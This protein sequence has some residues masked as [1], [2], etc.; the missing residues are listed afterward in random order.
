MIVAIRPDASPSARSAWS[1]AFV[2][3]LPLI[4][5]QADF[6]FRRLRAEARHEMVSEVVANAYC[7]FAAAVKRERQHFAHPLSLAMYAI[8]QVRSGRM[9][10][11]RRNSNDVSSRYAQSTKRLRV[12]SLDRFDP[13]TRAWQEVLVA[14]RRSGPAETAAARLD[15]GAW[16]NALRPEYRRIAEA[17]ACGER[18]AV[19]AR[20]FGK[21]PGR[22]SQLR[23]ELKQSWDQ[24]QRATAMDQPSPARRPQ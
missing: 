10:G 20:L 14:D 21:S 15:T 7:A 12:E 18:T 6:A 23:Q 13:K 9:T 2:K 22:I 19:V 11:G 8:R 24:F 1:D 3:M 5:R 16:L 17:L 4:E